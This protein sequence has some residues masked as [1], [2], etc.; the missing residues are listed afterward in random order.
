MRSM[1][2]REQDGSFEL[3]VPGGWA[4]ERDDEGGLLLS[5]PDGYGAVH[6]MPF[7]REPGEEIDAADELYAFLED[8]GIEVEEDEVEDIELAGGGFLALCEYQVEEGGEAVYWL[9]G[10]ATAPG[11]LVFISYSCLTGEEDRESE[12]V[13]QAVAEL[14]FIEG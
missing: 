1:R 12:I 8:Q 7:A 4:V 10:V 13:R 2:Y 11:Q 9:V 5:D 14:R 6:L 3:A